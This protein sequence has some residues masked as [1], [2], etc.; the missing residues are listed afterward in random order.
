MQVPADYVVEQGT[1]YTKWN[2]G[3]AECW[4]RGVMTPSSDDSTSIGGQTWYR[5]SLTETLPI[6]FV[7]VDTVSATSITTVP[8]G[9]MVS[10][11]FD[12]TSGNTVTIWLAR[13]N[14]TATQVS[15]YLLGRWK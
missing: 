11:G 7:A 9:V 10:A 15:W 6:N 5:N 2:S 8:W 3:K 4:G 13:Y 12:V 14:T 1:N